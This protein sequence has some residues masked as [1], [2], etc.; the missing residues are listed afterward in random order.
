MFASRS[1]MPCF[2]R[3]LRTVALIVV[4]TLLAMRVACAQVQPPVPDAPRESAVDA[5]RGVVRLYLVS[6]FGDVEG[7]VAQDN[8][9][10]RF[11]PHMGPDLVRALKPGDRFVAQG[12]GAAGRGFRAYAIGREGATPLVEARPSDVVVPTPPEVRAAALEAMHVDGI[13]AAILRGPRDEIDGVL[14]NDD[15]IVRLPPRSAIVDGD[16]L[17]VGAKLTAE[18]YGTRNRYGR[19]LRAEKVGLN[20]DAM[21]S[22]QPRGPAVPPRPPAPPL[23]PD[24]PAPN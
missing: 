2:R 9:Q 14:M 13:V 4:S 18:G 8:T 12:R 16:A 22:L 15:T 21:A 6:E 11:P 24:R 19:A 10:V 5:C 17:R 1:S 23:A 7:I 20:G 3:L